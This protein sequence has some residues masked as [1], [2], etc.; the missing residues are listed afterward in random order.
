MVSGNSMKKVLWMPAQKKKENCFPSDGACRL[1]MNW[2]ES[3]R[4]LLEQNWDE[5]GLWERK[6]SVYYYILH[7]KWSTITPVAYIYSIPQI[8]KLCNWKISD[9][10]VGKNK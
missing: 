4:T 8:V 6:V 3:T 2:F 1:F 7:Y 9:E 5:E 10:N